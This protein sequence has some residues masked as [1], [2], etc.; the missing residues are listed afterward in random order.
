MP[1]R[2]SRSWPPRSSLANQTAKATDEISGQIAAIQAATGGTVDAIRLIGTI[3]PVRPE[4]EMFASDKRAPDLPK[5]LGKAN[6]MV[7]ETTS[8]RVA[9]G[10]TQLG[11]KRHRLRGKN[12]D[13]VFR[14]PKAKS[15]GPWHLLQLEPSVH[16]DGRQGSVLLL[17]CDRTALRHDFPIVLEG[18]LGPLA[19][20]YLTLLLAGFR[21]ALIAA[22]SWSYVA[23]GRRLIRRRAGVHVAVARHHPDHGT[24]GDRIRHGEHVLHLF[25]PTDRRDRRDLPGPVRLGHHRAALYATFRPRTPARWIP[26]SCGGPWCG[27]SSSG[28]PSCGRPSSCSTQGLCSWLLVTSSLHSFVLERS[29]VTYGFTAVAIFFSI[30]R[31]VATM[32]RDD[33]KVEWAS[34]ESLGPLVTATWPAAPGACRERRGD[35]RDTPGGPPALRGS[36]QVDPVSS[37]HVRRAIPIARH[38][39]LRHQD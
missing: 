15:S 34:A 27:A 18:V 36:S 12:S 17:P 13:V 16:T 8:S 37:P 1:A 14:R 32:R 10:I 23:L 35:R 9:L 11:S 19:L 3:D 29:A 7:R 5:A 31:F 30:T 33:V 20:F 6:W 39:L 2:A 28:S 24:H 38:R 4:T 22:L 26:R 21:G 25:C